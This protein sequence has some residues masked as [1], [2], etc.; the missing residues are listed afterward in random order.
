MPELP[1]AT[2][3]APLNSP[4]ASPPPILDFR[5]FSGIVA[6]LL[7]AAAVLLA[8]QPA[9]LSS[10][11]KRMAALFLVTL[12]LWLTEAI[13]TAVTALLAILLQPIFQ[14]TDVKSAIDSSISSVFFFVIAMFCIAGAMINTGLALRFGLWLL[15]RAGTDTRRI[16]LAFMAGTATVSTI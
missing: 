3:I 13:P 6:A 12:V 7:V 11:G 15:S 4:A 1:R 16:V 2:E 14:V 5:A 8:P 9:G 10:E